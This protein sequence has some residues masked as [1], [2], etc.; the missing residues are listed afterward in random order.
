MLEPWTLQWQHATSKSK[1]QDIQLIHKML[2]GMRQAT[3]NPI[4]LGVYFKKIQYFKNVRGNQDLLEQ[5][6]LLIMLMH[7]EVNKAKTDQKIM[8]EF[9]F[10]LCNSDTSITMWME[11]VMNHYYLKIDNSFIYDQKSIVYMKIS[12]CIINNDKK[13]RLERDL[14]MKLHISNGSF[15]CQ[16]HYCFLDECGTQTP[17]VIKTAF[18]APQYIKNNDWNG[19]IL[20]I[21]LQHNLP[22][23]STWHSELYKI[24][25]NEIYE[26]NIP[27]Y[28]CFGTKRELVRNND[29]SCIALDL[30]TIKL[31][32]FVLSNQYTLIFQNFSNFN[33]RKIPVAVS[34]Q[35][36]TN[37]TPILF[38]FYIEKPNDC[39]R[40]ELVKRLGCILDSNE[41]SFTIYQ[42]KIDGEC[43]SFNSDH[44]CNEQN[45]DMVQTLVVIVYFDVINSTN[46]K[47]QVCD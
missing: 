36:K 44:N 25:N 13:I 27:K 22:H 12:E 26:G 8:E 32:D 28:K 2:H 39:I 24:V 45:W 15:N 33:C 14:T 29:V 43:D 10:N 38:P 7:Q 19:S 42:Y 30:S 23:N 3:K 9:D 5:Y 35:T 47:P 4:D 40:K 17:Q 37:T 34:E 41:Y 6:Q 31:I 11:R 1:N 16:L 21:L 20:S 46:W 18:I